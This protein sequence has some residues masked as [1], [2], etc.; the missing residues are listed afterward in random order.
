MPIDATVSLV[1]DAKERGLKYYVYTLHKPDGK[2]FYVGKGSGKRIK[3]TIHRAKDN[4]YK[5]N[6]IKKYGFVSSIYGFY[7]T[8]DEAFKNEVDLINSIGLE[9][10]TNYIKGGSQPPQNQHLKRVPIKIGATIYPSASHAAV[11]YGVHRTAILRWL[12]TGEVGQNHRKILMNGKTHIGL[13]A[14]T[15][16]SPKSKQTLGRMLK[17]G[18]VNYVYEEVTYLTR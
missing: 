10:L 1:T 7:K 12:K 18:R 8:E 2:V 5:Y 4:P 13:E 6:T 9:N 16:A 15:V 11:E 17:D 3:Q 14:A